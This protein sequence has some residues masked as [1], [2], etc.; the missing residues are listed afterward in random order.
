[1]QKEQIEREK[2][3]KSHHQRSNIAPLASAAQLWMFVKWK[4]NHDFV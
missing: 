1:M 4:K 3:K 2:E